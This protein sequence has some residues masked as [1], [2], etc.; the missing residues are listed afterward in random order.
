[1]AT[2]KDYYNII[3]QHKDGKS[4]LDVYKPYNDN[5][6][7]LMQDLDSGSKVANWRLMCWIA[8]TLSWL[9]GEALVRHTNEVETQIANASHTS[10]RYYH[11]RSL[12]FQFG[13]ALEYNGKQY[14]YL[15][16]DETAR[17]IKRSS[18]AMYQGILRFKVT[19]E[20]GGILESL[21][22]PEKIA[23][24]DYLLDVLHPGINYEVISSV[25]DLL[26][27]HLKIFVNPQV[28]NTAGE[29]VVTGEP[30]VENAIND[31]IKN[32]PFDGRMNIQKLIDKIQ[33]VTG[34]EDIELIEAAY[35]Y[36]GTPWLVFTREIEPF[37]GYMELDSVNSNIEY[38]NYV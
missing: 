28:L 17:I 15:N 30:L 21:T 37:A 19:K 32:L 14:V 29:H 25:A 31:F 24:K 11:T 20:T 23:F 2:I 10:L 35:K 34:V 3:I 33:N 1:M 16:D 7:A 26:K 22:T 5:G 38:H 8:A 18:V 6:A 9:L 36:A 27:L 12:G 4:E 13:H